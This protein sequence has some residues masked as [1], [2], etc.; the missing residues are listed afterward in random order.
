MNTYNPARSDLFADSFVST[1][2][3]T[4]EPPVKPSVQPLVPQKTQETVVAAPTAHKL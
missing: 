2:V 1:K 4:N 3:A